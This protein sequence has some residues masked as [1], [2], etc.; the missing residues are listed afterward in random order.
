[1]DTVVNT[2]QLTAAT[3][4]TPQAATGNIH[5]VVACTPCMPSNI[6]NH[7]FR[8]YHRF[9]FIVGALML[10]LFRR[11]AYCL[12]CCE[13]AVLMMFLHLFLLQS[14]AVRKY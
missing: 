3:T 13:F 5:A 12:E 9:G 10:L 4:T 11:F 8:F 14:F 7:I 2:V 1:M 6:S